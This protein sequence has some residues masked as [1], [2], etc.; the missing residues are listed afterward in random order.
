M[1]KLRILHRSV[2]ISVKERKCNSLHY[3]DDYDIHNIYIG[4]H[5]DNDNETGDVV[6]ETGTEVTFD[7]TERV[8]I[9]SG[10]NCHKG[11][12]LKI[13]NPF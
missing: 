4:N 12:I 13:N 2:R 3:G 9:S 10:F 8:T 6:V 7:A 11:G 5:V 1:K